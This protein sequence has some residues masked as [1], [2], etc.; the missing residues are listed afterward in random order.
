M[1]R[2]LA[3]VMIVTLLLPVSAKQKDFSL[4]IQGTSDGKETIHYRPNDWEYI[5]KSTSYTVSVE[6]GALRT[7]QDNVEFH[8]VTIYNEPYLYE[9]IGSL[10][11]KIYTYG[12]LS[13]TEKTLFIFNEVYVDSKEMIVFNSIHQFGSY[14]VELQTPNTPRNDIFKAVCNLSI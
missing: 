4:N 11:D 8:S 7:E 14:T 13:C 9:S 3:L 12:I 6:K 10:I 2:L 1:K 5:T